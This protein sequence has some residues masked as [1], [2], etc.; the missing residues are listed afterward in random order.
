MA[1]KSEIGQG[2][3]PISEIYANRGGAKLTGLLEA[4][5]LILD[6]VAQLVEQPDEGMSLVRAQ[7]WPVLVWMAHLKQHKW[8]N[9]FYAK[10][11]SV[12]NFLIDVLRGLGEAVGTTLVPFICWISSEVERRSCKAQVEVSE[13]SSSSRRR[14]CRAARRVFESRFDSATGGFDSIWCRGNRIR[15][16]YSEFI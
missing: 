13:S 1:G 8:H 12:T 10:V 6:L 9:E 16:L 14:P 7:P 2:L 3:G 15:R 4:F 11:L 5:R